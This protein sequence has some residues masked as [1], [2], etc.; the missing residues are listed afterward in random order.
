MKSIIK[1]YLRENSHNPKK[2]QGENSP[3]EKKSD[4]KP[5][6]GSYERVK[7]LLSSNIFNHAGIIEKLWGNKDATNRSL[8]RKKLNRL[9][10]GQGGTYEFSEE[11]L[12]KIINILMSAS[13]DI[14]NAVGRS[15]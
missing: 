9:D 15:D 7:T 5:S 3:T 6:T 2:E 12:N 13:K 10:N 14:K 1:K 4:K 8:F 11:E